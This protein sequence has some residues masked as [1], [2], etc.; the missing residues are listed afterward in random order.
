[1]NTEFFLCVFRARPRPIGF[2]F[3]MQNYSIPATTA[4]S[5]PPAITLPN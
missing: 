4:K 5:T 3:S 2:F 1:M